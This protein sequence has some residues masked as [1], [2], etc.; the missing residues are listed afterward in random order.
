MPESHQDS[1]TPE[2]TWPCKPSFILQCDALWS[3]ELLL[4]LTPM[5]L[6]QGPH[7]RR[8]SSP[9]AHVLPTWTVTLF[10]PGWSPEKRS[11]S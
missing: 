2:G 6:R 7:M 5:A 9:T 1:D 4:P 11:S 10:L 8:G 3:P